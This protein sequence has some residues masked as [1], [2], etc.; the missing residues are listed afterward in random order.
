M[1]MAIVY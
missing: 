1:L